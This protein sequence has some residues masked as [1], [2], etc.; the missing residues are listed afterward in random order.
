MTD[1]EAQQLLVLMMTAWPDGMRFLDKEQQ[2]ETRRLYRAFLVDLDYCAGD[3]AVARLIATWKPTSSRAWPSIAELRTAIVT[4][5]HGRQPVAGEA[6]GLVRRL[7]SPRPAEEW[8]QIDPLIRRCCDLMG[9]TR[10]DL[11]LAATGDRYRYRVELG[12]LEAS[13]RARFA[14]L[15]DALA[16]R[17]ISDRVVGQLAAPIP[18]RQLAPGLP[19]PVADILARLLPAK[20]GE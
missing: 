16:G 9:W 15:Y 7:Q 17:E 6:W 19:E 12:D 11:I 4:Q 5:Q 3:A 20:K 10:R 13:D 2:A 8:E 1:V 18:V 14:E